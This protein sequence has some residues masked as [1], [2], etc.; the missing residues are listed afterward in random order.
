MRKLAAFLGLVG[1]LSLGLAQ[2]AQEILDRV[3]KNLSTPGRPRS[4][5]GSKARAERRSSLPGCT[6]C[7]RPGSSGWS[8]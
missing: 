5:A 4:K 8:F 2:S 1:L 6:P 7:P 3:E